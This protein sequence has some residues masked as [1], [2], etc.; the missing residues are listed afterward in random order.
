M[1]GVATKPQHLNI[2]ACKGCCFLHSLVKISLFHHSCKKHN[3]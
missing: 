1:R 2:C 3:L